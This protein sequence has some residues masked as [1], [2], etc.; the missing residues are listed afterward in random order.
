MFVVR[1]CAWWLLLRLAIAPAMAAAG[2][3]SYPIDT[4][5]SFTRGWLGS[6]LVVRLIVYAPVGLLVGGM[7]LTAHFRPGL[8][9]MFSL[10]PWIA[11]VTLL[12][13]ATEFADSAAMARVAVH[14]VR[15]RERE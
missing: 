9:A 4:S 12:S 13:A 7:A 8:Q 1:L 3:R 14:I 6:I 2:S 5:F 11:A 10:L 15:S